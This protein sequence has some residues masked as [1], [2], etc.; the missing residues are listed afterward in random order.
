MSAEG[1]PWIPADKNIAELTLRVIVIGILLGGIM[2][3][4][5]AYL[6]LYVGMTVSASIPAAVMSM[7]ILRGFKFK[8]VTIL[9]NNSVQTMASAGE[10]L[11]AGII[12]T[13]PALLVLGI[14]TEI[15][16][17]DTLMIALLGGLLGTMFTIALRRLFIVEEALPYPEGVACK[18]VLVAG[19]KGGEGLVA[20]IYALSIGA[21]YG[22]FVK[23]FKVTHAHVE[24]AVEFAGT[25]LYAGGELS[26][27]LL[28]VGF[29]VGLRI[30]SFIFLGGVI[31]FGILVPVYGLLKGWPGTGDLVDDFYTVWSDQIRYV[32]VG[33]MVVGGVY[34]LWSMRKTIAEGL[35]KS[36]KSSKNGND[37]VLRTEKDLPLDKVMMFCGVLIVL[38]F[39]FYWYATGNL[40][41]ALAGALFLAV[42]SFFFAA[43]AGY[44]AGVV[45]SSNSP[46]SG[47][48]IATLLFTIGLVWVVGGLIM[49]MSQT[50]M[51]IATMFI[52]AIVATSAA[53]AGDVM[54]DLKTG[55]MV[56]ATPW[57]QQTAEIIGV[58]VGALVIGPVLSILH[59]AFQISKTACERTNLGLAEVDQYDCKDAL[60]APQ[61]ELIGAIVDGAFGGSLNL[62]MVALGA[63]IAWI[64]IK[65]KMPVMSVAIGIYLPLALSV[66]I[67]AGGIIA[68][69]LLAGARFRIDGTL[70]GEPS[71][72]AKV[73]IQE[74]QDRG[75]L[76]GA[77]FIAGES[78]MG[79]LLAVFI[80]ADINPADW[81]GGTLGNMLSLV[82]FGWF[83]AVFISLSARSLP[84]KGNLLNDSMEVLS[85]AAVRLK[86]VLTPPK[87]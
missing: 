43:V 29:I 4:A 15:N 16:W 54:Q 20:I 72:A 19:E 27:A 85:D 58:V 84:A 38:T 22:W 1:E 24:G 77:G 35:I 40:V 75:V 71:K 49:K 9:E 60:F 68:H 46:V 76:I 12:F 8:D 6:G 41:M 59:K 25:R 65:L 5:N 67:M 47:M 7:L 17:F 73:A 55:H 82:F 79:V 69:V 70:Q 80:V 14:W 33:A 32:G 3:A 78:L 61:A 26:L 31:G 44:I 13:V 37:E 87:K 28:S 66:P 42:V 36:F 62:Q 86:S 53:I 50:D 74:V 83:V 23:A 63:I 39:L 18:E 64:L 52:A 10:S 34:T 57:R 21:I 45:G 51:M 56:G 48:T 30:A 11:A 81:I 2:T